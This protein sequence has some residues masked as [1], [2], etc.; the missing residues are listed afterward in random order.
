MDD[1]LAIRSLDALQ[2]R[3][4]AEAVAAPVRP[5]E[6]RKWVGTCL[7]IAGAS[8]L[9]AEGELEEIIETPSV[10]AIPGTK[11][12]VLGVGSHRGGLIP[13]ISGDVFF[14]KKPY[15]GRT[16]DYCM[17][18]SR[19]GFYC[20]ITLSAVERD[21]KFPAQLRDLETPVDPDF[22]RFCQGGFADAK[23]FLA[24]LDIDKLVA[25]S[26]FSNAAAQDPIT[27]EVVKDEC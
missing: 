18:L 9:V 21:M 11:P 12:W 14:R 20:G 24:V 19:P 10:M 6:R 26:D 7:G 27:H 22:A 2:Q 13:V 23:R 25:D 3:Y 17:V 5:Q 15:S 1:S 16:R 8:L 4:R